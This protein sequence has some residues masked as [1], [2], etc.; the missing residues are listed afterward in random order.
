MFLLYFYF[1]FAVLISFFCSL[2][3]SVILSVP[4]SHVRA[5]SQKN[6]FYAPLLKKLKYQ[7]SR[8]LSA[9][10]TINTIANTLGAAG[11]GA[12][13]HKVYGNTYVTLFSALLTFTILIFSEIIPKTLGTNYW[14]FFLPFTVYMIQGL[15]YLCY[16]F[17][18]FSHY[19]NKIIGGKG[20]NLTREDLIGA[21]EV[22]AIE[23]AI[24]KNESELLKNI[25]KLKNKKV[26]E[27]MTPRTVITAFD[28]KISVDEVVKKYQPLR[29]ARIPVYEESLDQVIGMVH[30]YKILEAFSQDCKK[31]DVG[32]YLKPI[33]TVPENIS[34]TAALDQF[35]K[36]K[37]HIFTVVDEYG[38][39]S[40]LVTM[41]DVVETILGIEIVDELD[42]VED[43]RVQALKQWKQ[44]KNRYKK[45]S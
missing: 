24:H 41:E 23:G 3:E 6:V 27:I 26:L 17:V 43:L 32:T 30:R 25:L 40:G 31:V 1:T 14:R 8:P 45:L 2:L 35:I 13:V 16:P 12:E 21:A 18:V 20:P 11:V 29:F 34:V 15:I 4:Y 7:I 39:L 22:G 5:A 9:I 10:L 37:E 28:K 33:H 38:T 19:F 36:R 44:K 42:P